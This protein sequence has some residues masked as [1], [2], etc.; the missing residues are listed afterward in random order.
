MGRCWSLPALKTS[1]SVDTVD[2]QAEVGKMTIDSFYLYLNLQ[3]DRSPTSF[4]L[5][6]VLDCEVKTYFLRPLEKSRYRSQCFFYIETI[7]RNPDRQRKIFSFGFLKKSDLSLLSI[8]CRV[9]DRCC[10]FDWLVSVDAHL[11][12]QV[13]KIPLTWCVLY[14][15]WL[16]P[17]RVLRW[18]DGLIHSYCSSLQWKKTIISWDYSFFFNFQA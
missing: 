17:R 6:K 10:A 11:C 4:T 16:Y 15:K 3:H 1:V 2:F 7:F 12:F 18:L 5:K 14:S 8:E 13:T 9:L